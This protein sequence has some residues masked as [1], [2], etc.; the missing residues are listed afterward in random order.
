MVEAADVG[1]W[2]SQASSLDV[3]GLGDPLPDGLHEYR[4]LDA[5]TQSVREISA[6]QIYGEWQPKVMARFV[7]TAIRIANFDPSRYLPILQAH[8][9][10]KDG[11]GDP[12]SRE[13][14]SMNIDQFPGSDAQ[15]F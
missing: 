12:F 14:L 3:N 10:G 8:D 4:G 15:P 5:L 7:D 11:W 9:P 1:R 2:D 6:S 13:S